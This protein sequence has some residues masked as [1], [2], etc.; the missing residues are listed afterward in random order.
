[1]KSSQTRPRTTRLRGIALALVAAT[2][3][4]G[5][6]APAAASAKPANVK[7]MSRNLYL[8][9][10]LTPIIAAPN[11]PAAYRAA[12]D[13]WEHVEDMN[14]P[15]RAKLLAAEINASKPHLI[16]LQEVSLWRRGQFGAPDGPATPATEVVYDYLDTLRHQLDRLGLDY[17]IAAVQKEADIE[18]PVDLTDDA[19]AN[20]SFDGRL[21]IRDVILA[22]RNLTL[23]NRVHENYASFVPAPTALGTIPILRGYTAV[24][25]RKG[26]RKFRFVNTHLEAFSAF[27]R[28]N[29]ATELIAP[30]GITDTDLPVIL[31]GDLNSDPDDLSSDPNP[32]PTDNNAAYETVVNA[33]FV[34]RGVTVPTCCHDADLR[35][36][37][38]AAF[39]SRIDH[40][41]S[42]GSVSRLGASLIGVDP[43]LRT[44]TE[45]W[46]TDHGGVVARLRVR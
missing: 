38:P 8:G 19:T 39:T 36:D 27:F 16:G 13:V 29:Q 22:K 28:K 4:T 7:V 5:L 45:L 46:P 41:L 11:A 42:R 24:D 23:S 2:A 15:A 33:G 30:G 37:P 6:V 9:A 40:V 43:V 14:F 17:R 26:D 1:M 10:D 34:D 32:V 12:G 35:N 20:P 18:A 25:V 44:P 3:I 31:L 21:T